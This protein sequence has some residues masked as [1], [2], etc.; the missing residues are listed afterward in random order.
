MRGA[1]AARCIGGICALAALVVLASPA[2]AVEFF[3][4]RL[5]IHGF[6]EQ[7]IR[8]IARDYDASD[9]WDLTQWY[10]IL[11]LEIEGEIAPDGWGPFDLI[12]AFGRIEVRYDCVWRR[13][14]GIFKS[15]DAYGDRS[16]M[17]PKR[18]MHARREGFSGTHYDGY[19][20]RYRSIPIAEQGLDFR[21]RADARRFATELLNSPGYNALAGIAGVDGELGSEDDPF[22]YIFERYNGSNCKFGNVRRQGSEDGV[23]SQVLPWRPGC[24][25]EANGALVDRANPLRAG[26]INPITGLAGALALPLRPAPNRPHTNT[27]IDKAVAQG[28]WLP[29]YRLAELIRN[30]KFDNSDQSFRQAELE[31]NRGASQQDDLGI[32]ELYFD[33]EMFDSRLWLRIGKQNIVWGKTELFRTTDQFNPRDLAL[34]SLPSLEESRIALWALRAVWSFYNVGPLEDVRLEVAMNYDQFEPNDLGTC[35]EPYTAL[36]VCNLLWGQIAH[37]TVQDALAGAIKPPNPWN[38]WK[39][40]EVGGRLEWRYDRFSFA[41]TD[42]YGYHD[43]PYAHQIFRYSRNVDPRTGRPRWGMETGVCR[44]GREPACLTPDNALTHHSVN[45]TRFQ[46]ICGSAVGFSTLDLNSCGQT[47]FNSPALAVEGTSPLIPRVMIAL[48]NILAGQ[49]SAPPSVILG[50]PQILDGLGDL[51]PTTEAALNQF[52]NIYRYTH[53]NLDTFVT[54]ANVPTPLVPLVA[55]F[56]DGAPFDIANG[57]PF[58]PP[59]SDPGIA[60]W[61]LTGL[62][63]FLTDEQEA[64]LGCGPFYFTDCDINGIDLM[65]VEG[66]ALT[67]SWTNVEGTFMTWDTRWTDVAQPGTVGFQ[68]TAICTRYENG[69]TYILPGC[70]GPGDPGYDPGVDGTTGGAVHPFTGQSWR[71]EM[72]IVSWNAMMGLVVNST[73][74]DPGIDVDEWDPNRPFRQG[75][76]SF[77]EPHWCSAI[78]GIFSLMGVQRASVRAGGTNGFGR[79]DFSFHGGSD[80]VLRY[81]KR[82]VLGFSADFSEDMTKTNWGFEFTWVEGL[83]HSDNNSFRGRS[84]AHSFNWTISVDRPTFI[85]FLNQNRTFFFNSQ[86]FVQYVHKYEKGF[87]SNGPWNILATFSIMTGYFQ[88]RLL[89]GVTFVYDFQSNSGAA[90]PSVTYRFTENFSATVGLAGFWGRY[91]KKP[92]PIVPVA[93]PER[94]GRGANKSF[95]ENGLSLVRERD[96]AF[97][98]IRYTF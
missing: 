1:S 26:D 53:I 91:E 6:Y 62:A 44:T 7:Q 76:C 58:N 43:M 90:L 54:R 42:F 27:N 61:Y 28:T 93:L 29:N 87:T 14:C 89:P 96:E 67:Q 24:K 55:D 8:A 45:L 31:W 33:I 16:R 23:G 88:D 82:N 30:G 92:A 68:P 49:P 41:L 75:G 56:N 80:V 11:N 77:A 78:R 86:W 20:V 70:R 25:F 5:A 19:V 46:V 85:N 39:G 94:V 63:P 97:M 74:D 9:G 34:A 22:F 40:I 66:S 60:T 15:V 38:S 50:G 95:V 35:G 57:S 83:P 48:T 65:N 32:K 37:G 72:A 18:L 21:D 2:A 51:N 47:V 59:T 36:P 98:R 71:S 69:N 17:L 4:D 13:A 12:S 84:N 10:H 81:E 73:N 3:D 79:R 52:P 64:L